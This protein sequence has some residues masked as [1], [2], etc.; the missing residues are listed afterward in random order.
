MIQ[1][2]TQPE[3]GKKKGVLDRL[4][5]MGRVSQLVLLIGG[6]LVIF[7]PLWIVN[8]DQLKTQAGLNTTIS[9]LQKIITGAEAPKTKYEAE[10]AQLT[11]ETEAAKAVYPRS[12]QAP[13]I[14]D[15]LLE[16]AELHYIYVTQT[17][18]STSTPKDSIG[19]VLTIELVLK[20]QCSEFQNLL[21]AMG[22]RLPTSKITKVRFDSPG[23]PLA[24]GSGSGAPGDYTATIKLD[25]L[26]YDGQ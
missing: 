13:E 12:T 9:N 1:P 10:L 16:L 5:K 4:P 6:F 15:S 14:V 24:T 19:P 17:K 2:E 3:E 11:A 8:Q 18:L 25:V 21:L 7:V 22:D 23:G 20:G 26:C